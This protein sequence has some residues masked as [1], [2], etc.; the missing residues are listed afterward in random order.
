MSRRAVLL[1]VVATVGLAAAPVGAD[2]LPAPAIAVAGPGAFAAG[3]ATRVVVVVEGQSL[4]FA[5][6]DAAPHNLTSV[7][8][9]LKRV[10][11]G[12]RYRAVRVP[13]FASG[14]VQ[15]VGTSEVLGVSTL[16]PGSYVFRCT[17]HPTTMTGQLQVLDAP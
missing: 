3:F 2:P 14:D 7:A 15:M 11:V 5:S 16:K 6:A 9:T 4:Q 17:V 10:K 12:K 8:T 13:L 1:A